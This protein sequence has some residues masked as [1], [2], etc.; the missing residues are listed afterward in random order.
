VDKLHV[1]VL[2]MV[3]LMFAFNVAVNMLAVLLHLLNVDNGRK[4][5]GWTVWSK[6]HPA[7]TH[8]FQGFSVSFDVQFIVKLITVYCILTPNATLRVSCFWPCKCAEFTSNKHTNILIYFQFQFRFHVCFCS[9][10]EVKWLPTIDSKLALK[11]NEFDTCAFLSMYYM[12]S[13]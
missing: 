12:W 13:V 6:R 10:V 1:H 4:S 8:A 5:T 11:N 2:L 3:H 9:V 7:H